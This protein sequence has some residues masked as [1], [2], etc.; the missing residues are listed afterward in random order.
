MGKLLAHVPKNFLPLAILTGGFTL[1]AV[2]C[3]IIGGL[4]VGLV[5]GGVL[6]CVMQA[7]AYS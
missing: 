2:G 6:A 4:G 3:G 7:V 5:V 1:I